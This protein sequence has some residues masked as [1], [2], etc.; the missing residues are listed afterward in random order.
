VYIKYLIDGRSNVIELTRKNENI[1]DLQNIFN[2]K[3]EADISLDN[4]QLYS[5]QK[6]LDGLKPIYAGVIDTYLHYKIPTGSTAL[7]IDLQQVQ[8]KI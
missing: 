6:Y 5:D 8:L 1:F 4:N 7:I 2:A 3:V